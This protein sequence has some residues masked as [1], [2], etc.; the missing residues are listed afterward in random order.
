MKRFLILASLASALGADSSHA[1]AIG[2]TL[3]I[4]DAAATRAIVGEAANQGYRGMLA[5]AGAIRNR[6][7]LRGVYGLHNPSANQQPA[8]VW[9]WARRAW[10]ESRT[11]DI[12]L[13]ATHWENVKAFGHP[14]W[15][16]SLR[17]TVRIGDHQFYRKP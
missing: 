4:S 3:H 1:R 11:N 5:V 16:R 10:S 12:T 15:A 2:A 8:W 7:T 13:G 14:Y 6:G 17:K 9:S